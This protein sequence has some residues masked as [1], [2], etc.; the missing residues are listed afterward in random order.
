MN[1]TVINNT[2]LSTLKK[3]VSEIDE[4]NKRKKVIGAEWFLQSWS[5]TPEQLDELNNIKYKIKN[6]R[7]K[8]NTLI[9]GL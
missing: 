8:I 2:I 1:N 3:L 9:K 5:Y 6:N 7:K 4:A